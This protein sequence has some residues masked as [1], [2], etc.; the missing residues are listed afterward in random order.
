MRKNAVL[1]CS[2]EAPKD[3]MFQDLGRYLCFSLVFATL[4]LWLATMPAAAVPDR[5]SK[6]TGSHAIHETGGVSA[7]T[8]RSAA[9]RPAR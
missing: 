8:S 2:Q 7:A 3:S 5:E 9:A 4:F 1:T 6:A